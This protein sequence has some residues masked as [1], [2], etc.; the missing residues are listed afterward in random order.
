MVKMMKCDVKS[1][2]RLSIDTQG[3]FL[4]TSPRMCQGARS[5]SAPDDLS[6]KCAIIAHTRALLIEPSNYAYVPVQ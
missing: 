1:H 5:I 4:R 6:I 2:Q 3:N